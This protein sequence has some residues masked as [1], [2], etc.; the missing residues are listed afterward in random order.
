M[1]P[2]EAKRL[3]DLE[4][5]HGAAASDAILSALDDLKEREH[6]VD[7][8]KQL[9]RV[10]GSLGHAQHSL[11]LR[12]WRDAWHY[13]KDARHG[14]DGYDLFVDLIGC[15]HDATGS[16]LKALRE[17]EQAIEAAHGPEVVKLFTKATR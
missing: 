17:L 1:T 5:Q 10:V 14:L 8:N 13:V 12:H 7:P 6:F 16:M 11:V 15:W 2:G 4:D 3:D 9:D